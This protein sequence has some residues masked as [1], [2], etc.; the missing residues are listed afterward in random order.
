MIVGYLGFGR[1][2]DRWGL[3]VSFWLLAFGA[4]IIAPLAPLLRAEPPIAAN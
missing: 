3:P 2:A 4:A 1:A